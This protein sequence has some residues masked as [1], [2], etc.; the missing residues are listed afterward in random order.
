MKCPIDVFLHRQSDLENRRQDWVPPPP[1]ARK[2]TLYKYM[3]NVAS[4]SQGCVT[5]E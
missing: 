3:K 1:P 2:G 4:A 5:D